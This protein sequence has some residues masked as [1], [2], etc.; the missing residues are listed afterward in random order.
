[1]CLCFFLSKRGEE[2]AE[3]LQLLRVSGMSRDHAGPT[4]S[5]T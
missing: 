3:S 1:M 2:E 5:P 4:E